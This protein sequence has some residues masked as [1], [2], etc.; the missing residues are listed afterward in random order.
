MVFS[1]FSEIIVVY[2]YKIYDLL[3]D[4]FA[5]TAENVYVEILNN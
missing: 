2:R 4:F 3:G 5:I 1:D